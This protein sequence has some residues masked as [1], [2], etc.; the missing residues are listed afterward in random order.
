MTAQRVCFLTHP[1]PDSDSPPVSFENYYN[2]SDDR[3]NL[4]KITI[5]HEAKRDIREHIAALGFDSR[6]IFPGLKGVGRQL[7]EELTVTTKSYDWIM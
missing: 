7:S 3:M 4:C 5:P 6:T 2:V 1:F